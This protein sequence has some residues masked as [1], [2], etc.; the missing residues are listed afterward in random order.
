MDYGPVVKPFGI[1]VKKA[2]E[3]VVE[4]NFSFFAAFM[5]VMFRGPRTR[6]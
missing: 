5:A 1:T 6:G 4:T 2:V 3:K